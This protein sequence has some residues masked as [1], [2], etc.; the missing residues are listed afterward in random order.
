MPESSE[1]ERRLSAILSADVQGFSRLMG[2]D[3]PTT[4]RTMME[5]RDVMTRRIGDHRGRVVD[6]SGDSILAEFGSAVDAVHCAAALQGEVG[7]R[8]ADLPEDR[9][10]QF[11]I[12]VN[13]GEVLVEGD[14]IFGATIPS[15]STSAMASR[16]T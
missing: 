10:M 7:A 3:E 15:R 11:R 6:F 5:Y 14:Q 4:V 8:N 12:G 9:R 2:A 1:L 16:A 13:L